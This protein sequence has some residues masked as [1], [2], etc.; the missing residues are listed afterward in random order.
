MCPSQQDGVFDCGEEPAAAAAA[1]RIVLADTTKPGPLLQNTSESSAELQT[2][3][4]GH[5]P[6]GANSHASSSSGVTGLN[7]T[8]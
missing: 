6:V 1:L 4:W 5:G 8:V 7:L 3:G 2:P